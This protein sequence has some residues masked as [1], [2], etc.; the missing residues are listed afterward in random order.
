MNDALQKSKENEDNGK[1]KRGDR[2]IFV[3]TMYSGI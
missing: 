1:Y 3:I 2:Y